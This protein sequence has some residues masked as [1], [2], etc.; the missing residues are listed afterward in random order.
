ME[1]I[2][3]GDDPLTAR[4]LGA[5]DRLHTISKWG[6]GIDNI[7]LIAAAIMESLSPTRQALSAKKSLTWSLATSCSSPGVSIGIDTAVRTGTWP[8]PEGVSLAGRTMGLVGLGDI[9]MAV[10]SPRSPCA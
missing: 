3:V 6:V 1:G 8:K 9:G 7:D 5:A 10:V 4:V 2:I